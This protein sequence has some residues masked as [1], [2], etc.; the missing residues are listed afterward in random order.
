MVLGL[1]DS[2]PGSQSSFLSS[3]IGCSSS[4]WHPWPLDTWTTDHLQVEGWSPTLS[5][6]E[7]WAWRRGLRCLW[8]VLLKKELFCTKSSYEYLSY[9]SCMPRVCMR[10][11]S[12][13]LYK[14]ILNFFE[15]INILNQCI[16]WLRLPILSNKNCGFP[17]SSDGRKPACIAGHPG[18]TPGSG[19]SPGEGNGNPLQYSCLENPMDRGGL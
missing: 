3:S 9:F 14:K 1:P 11:F 16:L 8:E 13:S 12:P 19:R 6:R 7:C 5:P 10:F 4:Q 18:S 17:G 2:G 15:L